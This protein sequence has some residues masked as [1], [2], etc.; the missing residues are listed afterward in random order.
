MWTRSEQDLR[1]EPLR[2][3][4]RNNVD[5]EVQ[6]WAPIDKHVF[7]RGHHVAI[8][9]CVFI[10]ISFPLHLFQ[11]DQVDLEGACEA[12]LACSTCHVILTP[13]RVWVKEVQLVES[14]SIL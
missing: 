3:A 13:D 4:L 2:A 9:R 12:S 10:R 6:G 7:A 14:L 11:I 5:G 1:H 8:V